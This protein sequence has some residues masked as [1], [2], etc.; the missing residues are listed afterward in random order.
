MLPKYCT[1][2]DT[3]VC[4]DAIKLNH[5]V[6]WAVAV[7]TQ[8]KPA[9]LYKLWHILGAKTN[10]HVMSMTINAKQSVISL[11]QLGSNMGGQTRLM[12][13]GTAVSQCPEQLAGCSWP[14]GLWMRTYCYPFFC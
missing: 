11:R 10:P 14:L 5:M 2:C 4:P 9:I 7:G 3:V 12:T 8:T 13:I 6:T 1:L